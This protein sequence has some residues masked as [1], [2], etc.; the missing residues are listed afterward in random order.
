MFTE[1]STVEN[2]IRDTLCGAPPAERAGAA[3]PREA[4]IPLGRSPHGVGWH[5]VPV[6]ALHRRINEVFVEEF[7]RAALIRLNPAIAARPERAEEVIY[8]LRA[9]VLAVRS[10]GLIRANEEFTAWLRGERSMPVGPRNEHVA[11][12]L[13][14]IGRA[15]V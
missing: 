8:K 1:Q 3:E 15:H 11:I 5:Y 10:D 2:L 12:R 4:Y 14:K 13:L 7:A 6:L 9:I